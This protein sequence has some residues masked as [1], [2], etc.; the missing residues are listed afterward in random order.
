MADQPSGNALHRLKLLLFIL[1]LLAFSLSSLV[2]LCA[3]PAPESSAVPFSFGILLDGTF[4]EKNG[5]W[6][7]LMERDVLYDNQIPPQLLLMGAQNIQVESGGSFVEP[8]FFAQDARYHPLTQ[9]V[10]VQTQGDQILY[11]VTDEMGNSTLRSR[12]ITYVDTTPPVIRL[13]E[14]AELHISVGSEYTEPGYTA[15]DNADGIITDKVIISGTVNTDTPGAYLLTYTVRD[16]AGNQSMERRTVYVDDDGENPIDT[17]D[18]TDIS[19][20]TPQEETLPTE[21]TEDTPKSAEETPVPTEE[22]P[23]ETTPAEATPTAGITE[24]DTG[25]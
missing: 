20:T 12:T 6:G 9:K 14:A 11:E 10:Q 21:D 7:G 4:L 5:V 13:T 16:S 1:C 25:F 15:R 3:S 8:G 24:T 18:T 2:L 19:E 23:T 22:T 17:E